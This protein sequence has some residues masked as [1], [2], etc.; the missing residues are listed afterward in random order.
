VGSLVWAFSLLYFLS[1]KIIFKFKYILIIFIPYHMSFQILSI[2]CWSTTP[3]YEADPGVV[4]VY[5]VTPLENR[6]FPLLAGINNSSA[7]KLYP[8][9]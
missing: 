4:N 7:I 2:M 9:G 5:S 1:L 8:S 3:T 6:F